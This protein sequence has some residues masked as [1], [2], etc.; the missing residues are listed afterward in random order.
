M[1]IP[2]GLRRID[3]ESEMQREK[4]KSGRGHEIFKKGRE[5]CKQDLINF[6][7]R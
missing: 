1:V 6:R 4:A 3:A 7:V 5:R 2:K